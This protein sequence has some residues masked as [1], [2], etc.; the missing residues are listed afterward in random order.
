MT[1]LALILIS[2]VVILA[3][4]R[5]EL[6]RLRRAIPL[7][8]A[9]TGTR[10]KT[11]VV[12]LLASVLRESGKKVLA[13]TTGSRAQYVYPDGSIHDVPRRGIVSIL[14]QKKTLRKAVSLGVDCLVVEIMSVHPENH[15]VE[16]RMILKPQIVVLTNVRRDHTAAMGETEREI[17]NVLSLDLVPGCTVYLP[18]ECLH[19]MRSESQSS[20]KI[21]YRVPTPDA[22]SALVADRSATST[23]L[24]ANLDL[25]ITAARDLGIADPVIAQG[26]RK[27]VHD[28]GEFR[29]WKFKINGK[30]LFVA[31]AFAANDPLSTRQLL[32]AT[33]RKLAPLN[34]PMT[35]LLNLRRDRADRTLQWIDAL[36]TEE[37]M[38]F[39]NIFAVGGHARVLSRKIGGTG[40]LSP[41]GPEE[42][43]SRIGSSVQDGS[44]IF[45]FG[46]IG[47]VGVQLVE[48]WHRYGEPYGT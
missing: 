14:E 6:N 22:S 32:D 33:R 23:V 44:V 43:M 12:R 24:S 35:G 3:Y 46:N 45:G 40:I 4:E 21:R 10:G 41:G 42:I 18:D 17:A 38:G 13:K 28:V 34:P 19:L 20:E 30:Q 15:G 39:G 48:H 1:I 26:I 47:G 31:N 11:G 7:V 16:S 36:G 8:I 2:F 25:V 27:T 5:V 37:K 9:V 29:I